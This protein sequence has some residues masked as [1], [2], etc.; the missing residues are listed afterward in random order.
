MIIWINKSILS[1]KPIKLVCL[2]LTNFYHPFLCEF[3]LF[4][5]I[6]F[7]WIGF[8]VCLVLFLVFPAFFLSP[9]HIPHHPGLSS[10]AAAKPSRLHLTPPP[11]SRPRDRTRAKLSWRNVSLNLTPPSTI[12]QSQPPRFFSTSNNRS[13]INYS[14]AVV[15]LHLL[16]NLQAMADNYKSSARKKVDSTVWAATNLPSDQEDDSTD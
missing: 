6:W 11:I 1:T 5:L 13:N 9:A 3:L 12:H 14:L 8:C 7:I 15:G 2:L 4:N 16:S 10:L